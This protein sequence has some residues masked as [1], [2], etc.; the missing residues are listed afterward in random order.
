MLVAGASFFPRPESVPPQGAVMLFCDRPCPP[1]YVEVTALN[2]RVAVGTLNANGNNGTTGGS[3]TLT[4]AG[5]VQQATFT[6]SALA[7]HQH[8]LP[9]QK[10]SGGTGVFRMLPA[11]TFGVGTS[12]AAESV[13]AAPTANTT[14]AAVELSQGVS[15]GTPAGTIN[16]QTFTGTPGEN[17]QAFV[18]CIY[19]AK[20]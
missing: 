2:G 3:D 11:S 6:G 5:T 19:C 1:G 18:R 9:F 15:G 4:P 17:R 7:T 13:S 8:E 14:S 12:R 10:V 20:Q 16:A